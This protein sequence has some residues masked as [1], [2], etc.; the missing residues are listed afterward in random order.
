[1]K[2]GRFWRWVSFAT[3]YA[4]LVASCPA[5]AEKAPSGMVLLDSLNQLCNIRQREIL[6]FNKLII[7]ESINYIKSKDETSKARGLLA[8][9][10][11][12]EAAGFAE[13]SWQRLNCY[14]HLYRTS[15]SMS[16]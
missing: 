1:M 15:Q 3:V 11:A 14:D 4:F 2:H 8:I 6:A 10:S 16:R 9:K 5:F 12:K 13:I 7:Q